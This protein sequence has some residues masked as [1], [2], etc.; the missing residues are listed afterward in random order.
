MLAAIFS[1]FGKSSWQIARSLNQSSLELKC[2]TQSNHLLVH[3]VVEA[4]GNRWSVTEMA[5]TIALTRLTEYVCGTVPEH[6][7]CLIVIKFEDFNGRIAL[8][9]SVQIPELNLQIN[10]KLN[11]RVQNLAINF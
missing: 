6:R 4:F 2:R 9:W 8:Q 5:A 1:S 3:I 11:G 10:T 7:L